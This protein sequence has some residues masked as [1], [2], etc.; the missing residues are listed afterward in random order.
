[1]ANEL[2][3]NRKLLTDIAYLESYKRQ[4]IND[5]QHLE[6]IAVSSQRDKTIKAKEHFNKVRAELMSEQKRIVNETNRMLE[7]HKEIRSSFYAP[8]PE[9]EQIYTVE[10]PQFL[11]L[12]SKTGNISRACSM[13]SSSSRLT[14]KTVHYYKSE[15]QQFAKDMQIAYEIFQDRLD[16]ELTSRAIDGTD[17]PIFYRGEHTTTHKIPDNRLLETVAKAHIPDKYDRKSLDRIPD[18][19]KPQLNI[20]ILSFNDSTSS[21]EEKAIGLV[22][23]VL[24]DGSVIRTT[25]TDSETETKTT[26]EV[27]IDV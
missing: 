17:T 2:K 19:G 12:Y 10:R 5:I 22:S 14:E 3:F 1:M 20:N 21:I 26:E 6:T 24:D 27:I 23:E 15:D 16:G 8:T 25:H 11:E 4:L 13:M 9:Q 7:V 18:H